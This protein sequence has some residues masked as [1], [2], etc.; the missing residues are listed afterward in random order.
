[1]EKDY[2]FSDVESDNSHKGRVE[3]TLNKDVSITSHDG[4]YRLTFVAGSKIWTRS[5]GNHHTIHFCCGICIVHPR[6]EHSGSWE[7]DFTIDT[8]DTEGTQ[9]TL[10][11]LLERVMVT[12]V[13]SAGI[14]T[15]LAVRQGKDMQRSGGEST[16]RIGLAGGGVTS[17]HVRTTRPV[18]NVKELYEVFSDI[19]HKLNMSMEDLQEEVRT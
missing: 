6:D 10:T 3:A 16:Y 11:T 14:D 9:Q 7:H 1:V 18:N 8:A 17:L 15:E 4:K 19:N 12:L 2:L 13:N 5:L